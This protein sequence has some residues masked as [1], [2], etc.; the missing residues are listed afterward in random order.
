MACLLF[1]AL[2]S[3]SKYHSMFFKVFHVSKVKSQ[4]RKHAK[5]AVTAVEWRFVQQ[6]VQMHQPITHTGTPLALPMNHQQLHSQ[7][8][9]SPL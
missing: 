3:V 4:T 2:L 8:T 7:P 5:A 9:S 1:C 6:S